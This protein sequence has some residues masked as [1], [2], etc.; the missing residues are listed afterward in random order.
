ML[1]K[2]TGAVQAAQAADPSRHWKVEPGSEE[3]N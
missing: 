3:T 1:L 2:R